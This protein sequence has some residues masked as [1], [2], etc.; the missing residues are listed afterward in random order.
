MNAHQVYVI[1]AGI[2]PFGRHAGVTGAD[3]AVVATRA[4]LTDAGLGW[5]KVEVAV[6][7][8]NTGKPDALVARLGLTGVAFTGVRNGCATGGVAL[9]TAANALRA[10]QGE[11]AAVI[12]FD[13]HERGAFAADPASYGLDAWYGT[14]GLMV[15]TQYFAMRTRRYLH[16]HGVPDLTLAQI[17]A[18]ASRGGAANPNAWRRRALT[19]EEVLAAPMVSDPL[20]NLMF[21]Q[22]DEGA[23]ALIL[24]RGARAFDLCEAPV[25]L[26]SVAVRTRGPGSFEVFSPW[27]AP[28][29]SGSPTRAAAQDALRQAGIT[30]ADVQVAQVQDTDCGSE[31]IHL[32]ETGLCRDGEQTALLTD[33]ATEATGRLPVNTDGGCLANGEPIGASGLRQV[34]EVVRQLQVRAAGTAVRGDPR[35]GFTHVY[36]APGVSACTVLMR[37]DR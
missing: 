17:A 26:A 8:S 33:G 25:R 10:G 29:R 22:P 37:P 16:E 35:I 36:G 14:T 32:A 6:G 15:T 7:G 23:V 31:L 9:A 1:G 5:D 13:K 2:H 19:T 11:V 4:A 24:A 20:T 3:M 30:V 21:C 27:L 18:R 28:H 12:G 34:H